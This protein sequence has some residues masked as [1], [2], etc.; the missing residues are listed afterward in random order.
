MVATLE[1]TPVGGLGSCSAEKA[2]RRRGKR[3][4]HW[5]SFGGSTHERR[6]VMVVVASVLA[7]RCF[8]SGRQRTGCQGGVLCSLL[9]WKRGGG[10]KTTKGARV[11]PLCWWGA[12]GG[13]WG[14]RQPLV[15]GGWGGSSRLLRA[16]HVVGATAARQR[17]KAVSSGLADER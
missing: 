3:L 17:C 11:V 5:K 4:L 6:A 15:K 10:I 2:R 1:W 7:R 8:S 12:Y 13:G 9:K 16:A 14:G